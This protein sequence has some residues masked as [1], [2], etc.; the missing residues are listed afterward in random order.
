MNSICVIRRLGLVCCAAL[1]GARGFAEEAPAEI[2][3]AAKER[4][5]GKPWKVEAL[6]QGEKGFKVAGIINGP[7]FDLTI[8]DARGSSRQIALGEQ[9]WSS[10]DGG[11]TWN[12]SKPIDRRHYF[13]THTPIKFRPDA[14]IPPFEKVETS[15]G[16]GETLLHVRFAA[17]DAVAY[18]GD[19]PNH[20]IARDGDTPAAIRRYAGPI[21]FE[22]EYVTAQVRYAPVAEAK[23]I[24]P[25]PGNPA[26]APASDAPEAMLSA[27]LRRMETGVW[28][29]EG[30]VTSKKKARVHGLISGRNFDLSMEPEADGTP[31]RQIA[32]KDKSWASY[33]GGKTWKKMSADDRPVY[34]W[35]QSP[36]MGGVLPPFEAVGRETHGTE[37]W[38]HVRLK[39]SEKLDSEKERPHYWLA[40]DAE[41]DANG[42]RRYEGNLAQ[43]EQVIFCE[44]D[45]RPAG[46]DVAIKPPVALATRAAGPPP[47]IE[48]KTL[49]FFDIE[50]QKFDLAGKVVRVEITGKTLS[51][52]PIGG[53]LVRVMVKDI[54]DR[55]G[56]V[57]FPRAGLKKLGIGASYSGKPVSIYLLIMPQGKEPAAKATAVGSKFIRDAD[58]EGTYQW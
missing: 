46:K 39:V 34:L 45:Y 9:G 41:G 52:D 5:H 36:I 31:I 22:N 51:A 56:F 10:A 23:P 50:A 8:Q 21:G 57:E 33:D 35:V 19:R 16:D 42:V 28:A 4:M 12:K 43:G 11:K 15:T 6:V 47:P 2:L 13:I 26:A 54:T 14:K 49:G 17:P 7:D 58:G 1:L 44:I 30:A 53:D 40:L 24:L 3:R 37:S 32:I 55:Y 25:P 38:L 29:V 48:G 20:W 18:E 27:A